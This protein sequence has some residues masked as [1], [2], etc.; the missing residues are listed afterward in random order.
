MKLGLN[1]NAL[2]F[3]FGPK[4]WVVNSEEF[5]ALVDAAR[6]NVSDSEIKWAFPFL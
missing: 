3:A 4:G 2:G 5:L 1:E 6:Y